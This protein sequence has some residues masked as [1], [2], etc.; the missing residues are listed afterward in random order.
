LDPHRA[1]RVSESI[2]EEL[3][4]LIGY[5]MS[6]PRVGPVTV[7]AVHPGTFQTPFPIGT[8][9]FTAEQYYFFTCPCRNGGNQVKLLPT[10]GSLIG[11]VRSVMATV[12]NTGTY[13]ISKSGVQSSVTVP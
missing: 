3:D 12:S 7:S 6:D 10:D 9:S 1:E 11:I 13:T 5:E 2:R 8:T 4:E